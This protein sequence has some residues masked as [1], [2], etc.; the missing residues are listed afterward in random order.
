MIS[1]QPE[2]IPVLHY[3]L[4]DGLRY[5]TLTGEQTDLGVW[6]WRDG[7]ERLEATTPEKDLTPLIDSLEPGTPRRAGRAD[8]VDAE[9]LARALDGAR[10]RSARRSGRRRSPTT[11]AWRSSSIQPTQLH[12]AAAE[13]GAG[14]GDG[15]DALDGQRQREARAG[16]ASPRARAARSS[17]PRARGR[18]PARARTRSRRSS[19]CR[20]GSARRCARA[21]PRARPG[22]WSATRTITA[23]CVRGRGDLD[24]LAGRRV[25]QRVVDQ[26][27]HDARAGGR[28]GARP[29]RLAA[30]GDL[31][32]R[33]RAR[34]PA[35]RTRRRRRG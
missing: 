30:L 5:A 33:R 27:P 25:A 34:P 31:Q 12:A 7:V 17:A 19:P 11:R 4:P 14:D 32:R 2:T 22:P 35:A 23:R 8:H 10:A 1:T 29:A 15:E 21:P 3:Y 28:I 26:D 24:R 16:R 20:G 13:S 9:P 6:D 18:S